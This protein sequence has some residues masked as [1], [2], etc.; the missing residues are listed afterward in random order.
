[1]NEK[2]SSIKKRN[3]GLIVYPT[4]SQLDNL[5]SEYD[6]SN[7]YGTVPDNWKEVLN[8]SGL[9]YAIS[10]LHD[11]D[12]LEDGSGTIKK[13][14]YHVIVC[15]GNPTTYKNV[16]SL[17]ESLKCPAPQALEQVGGYYRYFTH[18]DN[19]DKYQYEE[20]EIQVGGGF[21]IADFVDLSKSEASAIKKNL[22]QLIR[23]LN[24][25]EYADL[26]DYLLDNEF[27][28]EYDVASNNTYFFD[29]YISSKRNKMKSIYHD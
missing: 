13:P 16:K 14:H 2:K 15:Y 12:K 4:K 20:K 19:A 23:E 25:F 8:L 3:W 21:S 5:R 6:G 7:G 27:F 29:K 18:K 10:P 26:M 22:Q 11:K 9:R 1:M 24:I 17:A 28:L